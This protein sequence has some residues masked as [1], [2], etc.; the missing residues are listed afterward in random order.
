MTSESR[1]SSKAPSGH[2]SGTN[3]CSKR[4]PGKSAHLRLDERGLSGVDRNHGFAARSERSGQ[5]ADRTAHL[6]RR[7]ITWVRHGVQRE[8]IFASLVSTRRELPRIEIRSIERVKILGPERWA[9][10]AHA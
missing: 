7:S 1:M 4:T 6:K 3:M 10:L 5:N 2:C 9:R 8:R